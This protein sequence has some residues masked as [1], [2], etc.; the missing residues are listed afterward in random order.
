MKFTY[1]RFEVLV[2]GEIV[3]R[4]WE[5]ICCHVGDLTRVAEV[6]PAGTQAYNKGR[7]STAQRCAPP[8]VIKGPQDPT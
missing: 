4:V 3:R 1:Y 8:M 7:Y 6:L 2:I 5:I